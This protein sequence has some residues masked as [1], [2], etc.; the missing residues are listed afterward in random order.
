[1]NFSK[2]SKKIF[3]GLKEKIIVKKAFQIVIII[4][5]LQYV[6]KKKKKENIFEEASICT[7]L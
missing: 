4:T 6:E 2:K 7:L 1:M 5:R 3:L